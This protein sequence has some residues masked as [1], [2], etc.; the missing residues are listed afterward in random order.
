[1]SLYK[2]IIDRLPGLYFV[3][4]AAATNDPFAIW[5]LG[6]LHQ[7]GTGVQQSDGL[8]FHF[9]EKAASMGSMAGMRSLANCYRDG[10]GIERD[11]V[12]SLFYLRKVAEK[13]CE[14]SQFE[15]GMAYIRGQG[16]K[17][18]LV[19]ARQ[20]FEKASMNAFV[21]ADAVLAWMNAFG[22]IDFPLEYRDAFSMAKTL[23]K[24]CDF[25]ELASGLDYEAS[26]SGPGDLWEAI[27][28]Y[29]SLSESNN[30]LGHYH[31]GRLVTK[32]PGIR[33]FTYRKGF[34]SL[35]HASN[36]GH[37][38]A[39][40]LLGNI[41]LYGFSDESI[42]IPASRTSAVRWFKLAA[43]LG[44]MSAQAWLLAL[45]PYE[46]Y[47]KQEYKKFLHRVF[48][49]RDQGSAQALFFL[50]TLTADAEAPFACDRSAFLRRVV[51][52][53][54][55]FLQLYD[56]NRSVNLSLSVQETSET[57]NTRRLYWLWYSAFSGRSSA[58]KRL[59]EI[60][61]DG[62]LCSKDY[63][64]AIYWLR[65]AALLGEKGAATLVGDL[66]NDTKGIVPNY[67]EAVNFYRHG[68]EHKDSYAARRLAHMYFQGLGVRCS[69]DK[70][71]EF[72]EMADF[73]DREAEREKSAAKT[74]GATASDKGIPS[75][76]ANILQ[77]KDKK[78]ESRV[79]E[80]VSM[81][82]FRKTHRAS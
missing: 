32:K 42:S 2:K 21:Q 14:L 19:A 59:G 60:L 18:D 56:F 51:S 26:L 38:G 37:S 35:V 76:G 41:Y 31:F 78:Q 58:M 68:L 27:R 74:N 16:T 75:K 34:D 71:N 43:D 4:N 12:K 1:M 28:C 66:L 82:E 15:V 72:L 63:S 22:E 45:E 24:E 29:Q 80:I 36:K 57:A 25:A 61:V 11:L 39:M 67:S 23:A 9:Y 79:S 65:R 30:I 70:G 49:L 48:D 53:T 13:G 33:G 50:Q 8:A 64:Q 20:W 55:P 7:T 73:W 6:N 44:H 81:D 52:D 77:L 62:D 69:S 47:S 5:M 54:A 40:V 3:E 17:K 46:N 10:V